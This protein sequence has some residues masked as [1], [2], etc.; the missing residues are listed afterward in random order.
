VKTQ[1]IA[2]GNKMPSWVVAGYDEYAKRLPKDLLPQL[3]ELP[4]GHRSKSASVSDAIKSE[5][6]AILQAISPGYKKVMLEVRGKNWSTEELSHQLAE[7]RMDGHNVSFVI[8]GPDGLSQTCL[9]QADAKW[10][11]SNL[12]LPHPLVRIVFIEQLYRAWTILQ[13]HPYHK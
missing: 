1:L 10:S 11:L 7:W 5:G 9:D 8:G 3:V 13:N 2:V 4:M 6:E 12:T